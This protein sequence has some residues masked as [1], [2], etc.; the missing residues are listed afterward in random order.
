MNRLRIDDQPAPLR[1]RP[2]AEEIAAKLQAG[3]TDWTY[4]VVEVGNDRGLVR[5]DI[6]DED[7][8]FVASH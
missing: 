4:E 2:L 7:G 1:S 5:I 6:F 3:D 8:E